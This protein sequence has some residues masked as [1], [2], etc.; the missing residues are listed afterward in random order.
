MKKQKNGKS[1]KMA[2]NSKNQ[3]SDEYSMILENKNDKNKSV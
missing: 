3:Q 2:K 1:E